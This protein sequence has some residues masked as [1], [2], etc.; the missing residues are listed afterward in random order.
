MAKDETVQKVVSRVIIEMMGSPKKHIEETCKTYVDKIKEDYKEIEIVK[1]Y[2]SAGKKA[3]DGKMFH[4][5]A[6]LD[7]EVKGFEH[8]VWFCF[9]F[10]PA[11]VEISE[12]AELIYKSTDMSQFVNDLLGKLHKVDMQIKHLAA[13]NQVLGK[14]GVVLM[15]NLI[16][17]LLK[18]EPKTI[19]TL[20]KEAGIPKEH[21]EKFLKVMVRDKRL[22]LKGK[23]YSIAK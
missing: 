13:E 18:M 8:L 10:W 7:M 6:E 14:N 2:I 23:K 1:E 3:E 21:I 15:K 19:D 4:V 17:A 9:D 12:H 11:S 5:F 22:T 20:V 16:I